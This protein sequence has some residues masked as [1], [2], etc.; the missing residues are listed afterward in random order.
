VRWQSSKFSFSVRADIGVLALNVGFETSG[1]QDAT[2]SL[3]SAF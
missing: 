3:S 1:L 2:I